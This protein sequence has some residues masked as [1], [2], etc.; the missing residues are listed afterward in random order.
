MPPLALSNVLP[1]GQILAEGG[2][3]LMLKSAPIDTITSSEAVHPLI[4]VTVTL[5]VV[6]ET[7]LATG[8]E[9]VG[10]LKPKTGDHK[11][12]VPPLAVSVVLPPGQIIASL[13]ALAVTAGNT[14]TTTSS[15]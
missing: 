10:S 9:I 7:G 6:V 4:S 1:P 2:V 11:Y 3:T 15:D 12:V 5:Y 8:F 13:P 14:L